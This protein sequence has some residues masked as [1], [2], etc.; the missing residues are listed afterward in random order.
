MK[1]AVESRVKE[2]KL[3]QYVPGQRHVGAIEVYGTINIIH[4]GSR[5]DNMS[6]KAKKQ[7][8]GRRDGREVFAF[9]DSNNQRV[10]TGWKSITF[11]EEEEEGIRPHEDPFLI[12]LQLDHYI[13]KKIL[14]DT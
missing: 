11:L 2:E 12:T 6:N 3:Q 9:G 1:R 10:T 13:T 4:G 5:I 7:C 8:T 14:V